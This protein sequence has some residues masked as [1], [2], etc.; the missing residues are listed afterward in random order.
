MN[1]TSRLEGRRIITKREAAARGRVSERTL[2]RLAEDGSGPRRVRLS[3]RRVGF[4]EDEYDEWLASRAEPIKIR[5][6]ALGCLVKP[7]DHDDELRREV[8]TPYAPA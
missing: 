5:S 2:D 1:A 3:A 8:D 4:F 6:A 7:A